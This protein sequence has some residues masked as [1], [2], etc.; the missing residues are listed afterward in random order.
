MK[1]GGVGGGRRGGGGKG[2]DSLIMTLSSRYHRL[3]ST[4][5]QRSVCADKTTRAKVVQAWSCIIELGCVYV[6]TAVA[7][8]VQRED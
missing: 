4:G 2:G 5:R 3:D 6:R 7:E 1:T 8:K